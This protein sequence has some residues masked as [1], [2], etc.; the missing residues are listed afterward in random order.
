MPLEKTK[1]EEVDILNLTGVSRL[2]IEKFYSEDNSYFYQKKYF[3]VALKFLSD[4]AK[5]NIPTTPFD[6]L[7]IEDDNVIILIMPITH[8]RILNYLNTLDR[9]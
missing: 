9:S 3:S 8:P 4:K 2:A 6:P 5:S 1:K 7:K